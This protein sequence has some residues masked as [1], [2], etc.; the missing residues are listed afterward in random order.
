MLAGV[1][2]ACD[3]N[4]EKKSVFSKDKIEKEKY[5]MKLTGQHEASYESSITIIDCCLKAFFNTVSI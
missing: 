4:R 1:L 2:V 5:V 3:Y